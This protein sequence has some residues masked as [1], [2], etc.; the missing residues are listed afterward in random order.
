MFVQFSREVL[1]DGNLSYNTI[2]RWF[3]EFFFW[4]NIKDFTKLAPKLSSVP[5][6]NTDIAI[7]T[8]LLTYNLINYSS[9][10][11]KK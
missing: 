3:E 6:A 1:I 10:I 4:E 5:V 9:S 8:Y 2:G 7:F 11:S